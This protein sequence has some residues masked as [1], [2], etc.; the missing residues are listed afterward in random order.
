MTHNDLLKLMF[1]VSHA[2]EANAPTMF[3]VTNMFRPMPIQI[4]NSL[5]GEVFDL[6][7][8][9]A[10]LYQTLFTSISM[11]EA[12]IDHL[13]R[14]SDPVSLELVRLLNIHV[15]AS[16]M[17]MRLATEGAETVIKEAN[18]DNWQHWKKD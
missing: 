14:L 12:V 9:S 7:A 15:S 10:T 3:D 17:A 18:A 8:A 13:E 6:F 2:T 4:K 1:A 11:A 16:M 5:N